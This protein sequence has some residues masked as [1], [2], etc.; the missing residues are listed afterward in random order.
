MPMPCYLV[1]EGQ[2]QGKIE[3]STKVKGHEGKILVQAVEHTIEIP[4]SPQTGLPTGKRVHGPMTLTKEIDKASPKLFQALTSGEQMKDVTLQYMRISPKGTEEV[5]YTV[6]L[7][8]AIITNV[9]A[10]TPICLAQENQQIGHME[11]VSLT[12]EK[13]TWTFEPDG[14]EAEDSWLAPKA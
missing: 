14:I 10:W 13:V 5:Y 4:K 3:G 7:Q 2:N 11:D 8:N 12:Y 1:L 6:K 9:R